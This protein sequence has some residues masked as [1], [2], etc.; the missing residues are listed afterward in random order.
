V[1]DGPKESPEIVADG[2][3]AA[4]LSERFE[5][6]VPDLKSVVTGKD[7]DLDGFIAFAAAMARETR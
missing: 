5:H 7:A 3:V 1:Y 2:I 4:V 6:Y